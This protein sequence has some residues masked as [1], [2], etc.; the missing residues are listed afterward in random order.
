MSMNKIKY[1][2]ESI[3]SRVE[4]MEER[5]SELEDRNFEIA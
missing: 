5:I 3:C 4:Q 2:I 1:A